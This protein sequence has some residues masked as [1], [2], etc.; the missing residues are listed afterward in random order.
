[1]EK[2]DVQKIIIDLAYNAYTSCP[3]SYP[4]NEDNQPVEFTQYAICELAT[5]Y[6][7]ERNELEIQRDQD[8]EI[9][10]EDYL[11]FCESAFTKFT[12]N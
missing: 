11:V 4:V 5:G 9:S 12:E 3:E 7:D 10:I 2:K 8:L 6:W 1:M